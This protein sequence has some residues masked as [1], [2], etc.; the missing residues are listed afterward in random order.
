MWKLAY[1]TL[2]LWSGTVTSVCFEKTYK[3]MCALS[4]VLGIVMFSCFENI[5]WQV[6]LI[7][8]KNAVSFCWPSLFKHSVGDSEQGESLHSTPLSSYMRESTGLPPYRC[9]VIYFFMEIGLD[10]ILSLSTLQLRWACPRTLAA[11]QQH[12]LYVHC[13][14]TRKCAPCSFVPL[15]PTA[16]INLWG[17]GARNERHVLRQPAVASRCVSTMPSPQVSSP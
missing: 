4:F 1:S 3:H 14:Y 11:P 15:T 2:C 9:L 12:P 10:L 6:E 7:L 5:H 16:S 8:F 13:A 17:L